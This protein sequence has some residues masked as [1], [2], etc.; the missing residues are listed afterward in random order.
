MGA[1]AVAAAFFIAA[2]D[3]GLSTTGGT[4]GGATGGFFGNS[5]VCFWL[6]LLLSGAFFLVSPICCMCV[7]F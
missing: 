6:W 1:A 4:T 7:V 2:S 5:D 3:K